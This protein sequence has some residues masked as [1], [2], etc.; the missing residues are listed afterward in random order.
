MHPSGNHPRILLL[1]VRAEN[2]KASDQNGARL[3]CGKIFATVAQA[4][5]I[6]FLVLVSNGH[7]NVLSE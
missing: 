4:S 7:L 6:V 5:V 3:I 1:V 2:S